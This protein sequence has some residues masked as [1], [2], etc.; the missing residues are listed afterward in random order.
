[1]MSFYLHGFFLGLGLI[2]AIGA[3]NAWVLGMSLRRYHAY[4]VAS[5]CIAID[6][7]LMAV[8]VLFFKQIQAVLPSLI[9]WFTWAGVL[10]L[11]WLAFQ[12]LMRVIK[13]QSGLEANQPQIQ[14][15]KSRAV[16][17]A[18]AISL[19]NPHVYLDTVVLLGSVASATER[20]WLFYFGSASASLCWFML[21]AS[22]GKPLRT[23]LRSPFRWRCFDATICLLMT[24]MAFSLWAHH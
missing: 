12:A 10:I 9:P 19:L 15:S 6:A 13:G 2:V 1:M 8:G 4:T 5:V 22:M 16:I 23:I 14:M 18:L 17:S 3:Q 7:I 21:L 24:W 11:L 20:P